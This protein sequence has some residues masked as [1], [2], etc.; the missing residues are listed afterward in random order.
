MAKAKPKAT[1]HKGRFVAVRHLCGP[2]GNFMPG[3]EVVR[4]RVKMATLIAWEEA[5]LIEPERASAARKRKK[6]QEALKA[7][8]EEEDG[9]LGDLADDDDEEDDDTGKPANQTPED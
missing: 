3:E 2:F 9:L 6:A 8:K 4:S 1:K 7:A 5:G